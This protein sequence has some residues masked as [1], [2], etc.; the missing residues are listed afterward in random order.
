MSSGI[1]PLFAT[2]GGAACSRGMVKAPE[3]APRGF[4]LG[5]VFFGTLPAPRH[6]RAPN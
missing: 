6:S 4:R 5:K 2:V 3:S 1:E